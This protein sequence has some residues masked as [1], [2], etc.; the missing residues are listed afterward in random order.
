MGSLRICGFAFSILQNY[1]NSD[2]AANRPLSVSATGERL[3]MLESVPVEKNVRPKLGFSAELRFATARE[4]PPTT[5]V[6]MRCGV[7]RQARLEAEARPVV[8]I[9]A[10][11]LNPPSRGS[12]LAALGRRLWHF[13][14]VEPLPQLL[15]LL[16]CVLLA[17]L[18]RP[19][20]TSV[21]RVISRYTPV[22]GGAVQ[23]V[24]SEATTE[25]SEAAAAIEAAAVG[26]VAE[27]FAGAEDSQS[28]PLV[29]GRAC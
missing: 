23:R 24:V 13:P 12:F 11:R 6:A 28:R 25:L 22:R 5:V 3:L 7:D 29:G 26:A 17:L 8:N 1:T 2:L 10:S 18:V 19:G 21:A 4:Q 20:P 14:A 9:P 16:N 15:F 27:A